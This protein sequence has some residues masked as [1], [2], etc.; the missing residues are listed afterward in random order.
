ME[1]QEG[2]EGDVWLN[3]VNAQST[4]KNK[5]ILKNGCA[6]D[7]HRDIYYGVSF[8]DCYEMYIYM[9]FECVIGM[10]YFMNCECVGMSFFTLFPQCHVHLTHTYQ[11]AYTTK[12]P[13]C[14]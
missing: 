5:Y 13:Q 8:I 11:H 12:G 6:A 9:N 7:S 4:I 2:G 1:G 10:S 14:K 3:N